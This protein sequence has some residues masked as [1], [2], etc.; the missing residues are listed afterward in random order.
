MKT[1][2]KVQPPS[3][4]PAVQ[5]EQ[6][7]ARQDAQTEKSKRR[8]IHQEEAAQEVAAARPREQAAIGARP[9]VRITQRIDMIG[10]TGDVLAQACG[11]VSKPVQEHTHH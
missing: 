10:R 3:A 7:E 5:R 4:C 1:R 8:S 6:Q 2:V 9:Q 11:K